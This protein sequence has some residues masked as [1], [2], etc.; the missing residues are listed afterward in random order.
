[1]FVKVNGR[2]IRVEDDTEYK[3]QKARTARRIARLDEE[4]QRQEAEKKRRGYC[5]DCHILLTQFGECS[6]CG[7]IWK[8]HHRS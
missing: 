3:R 6:K 5:L 1:M 2:Y 4:L 8:F 7:T